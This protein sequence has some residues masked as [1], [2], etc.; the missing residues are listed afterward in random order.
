MVYGDFKNLA[1]RTPSDKIFR[2]IAFNIAK[3][4]KYDADQGRLHSM[5]YQF[6]DN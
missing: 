3:N 5:V 1:Q 2:D 6:F 4:S